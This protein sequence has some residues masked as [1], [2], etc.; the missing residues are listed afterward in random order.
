MPQKW[1]GAAGMLVLTLSGMK[2]AMFGGTGNVGRVL[3]P[4]TLDAGHH[5]N[6]LARTPAS[7]QRRH[8]ALTLVAGDALDP[9][10]V[11]QT[12][13]GCRAAV[14]ALGGFGDADAIDAG[15]ANIM[16]AMPGA[17]I[18]RLVLVQGYHLPFPGDP[19]NLGQRLVNI[20]LNLNDRQLVPRSRAMAQ[21]LQSCT[22][23]DWTLVRV[24]RVV[25]GGPTGAATT[26]IQRLGPWSKVTVGDAAAAVLTVLTDPSTTH[27]A[28]MVSSP[29]AS[30]RALRAQPRRPDHLSDI[31]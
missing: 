6:L 7:V 1:H 25:P 21:R 18:T 19:D 2:I 4:M 29:R 3:L 28:P 17:G 13:D 12:L 31:H 27:T 9:V 22:D 10:A 24:P 11:A 15:T 20:Y 8:P 14:S 26:G 5:V 30:K 23:I 16:A